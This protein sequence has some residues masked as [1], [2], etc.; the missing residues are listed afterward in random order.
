MYLMFIHLQKPWK[1]FSV[2][3]TLGKDLILLFPVLA[4]IICVTLDR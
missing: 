3:Y 2:T 4:L 1:A